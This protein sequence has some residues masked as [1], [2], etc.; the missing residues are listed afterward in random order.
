MGSGLEGVVA[1]QTVLSHADG[2][3]GVVWVRGHTIADLV[4]YH[5]YEGA[6]AILWEGFAGDKLTRAQ[7]TKQLGAERTAAF[8]RIGEWLPAA[9]RRP[10]SD[11]VCMCLAALR[12]DSSPAT[13]TAVVNGR[14]R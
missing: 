7:I 8:S 11:G 2:Q 3:S 9:V 1:A 14:R 10:L 5:G 6:I 13:I 12:A 4:A